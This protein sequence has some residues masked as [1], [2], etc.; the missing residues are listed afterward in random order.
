VSADLAQVTPLP[1]YDQVSCDRPGQERPASGLAH[2]RRLVAS[3]F[4][5]KV[6]ETY[7]TQIILLVLS[8]LTSVAVARALGP[9][10]R[11][12]YA[13]AMAMGIIGV[14]FG[15]LGLHAS[16][17]YYL[18]QNRSLLPRLLGNSLAVS[19]G[20]GGALAFC[21]L[22]VFS[23]WPRLAPLEGN[24]LWLG[25]AWIPIGLAYLLMENLLLGLQDIR[26]YNKV[27]VL[28]RAL[29]LVL[30][31][32]LILS[33]RTTAQLV[34]VATLL[35]LVLS[36]G[37][38]VRLL[39]RSIS[40]FPKPSFS[41]LWGHFQV[42]IKAYLIAL[43]GY[44]LLRIDLLMVKYLLGPEEAGYYS[45]ASTMGDYILMLPTVI[46]LILFPRLSALV[47]CQEKLRQA[48]KV[49]VGTALALVPI[50]GFAGLAAKPA[51]RI[52][53]GKAFLP[54]VGAFLWL[55]PGIFAMGVEITLVQFLNSLGYPSIVVWIW[56][57]AALLN[58]GL[59]FWA[60]PHFG[61]AGASMVSSVS[62]SLVSLSVV[63]MV[64]RRGYK[65]AVQR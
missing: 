26:S 10:G 4:V 12:L 48:R 31:G 11:G 22:G 50:L 8:L 49:S 41:L 44:L 43:F 2:L 64:G 57:A 46:G 19:L 18:A 38:A 62:Y 21:A 37:W 23:A 51:V 29:T 17:T 59:N 45:I 58:I 3:D 55:I 13:V 34:F 14:Q 5:R 42:G 56:F 16:N 30:I 1:D 33:G 24:L 15:N 25:L 39:W 40:L 61:I 28:N 35:A 60:I 47:E 7:A 63:L 6:A 9:Q 36:L 32:S 52:V 20:L 53:F 27:E 54:A 65:A